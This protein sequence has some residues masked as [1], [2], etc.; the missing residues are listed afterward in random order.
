[1]GLFVRHWVG[2]WDRLTAIAGA[3]LLIVCMGGCMRHDSQ[4]DSLLVDRPEIAP[5]TGGLMLAEVTE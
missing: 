3:G 5:E 4:I 1:M 2:H